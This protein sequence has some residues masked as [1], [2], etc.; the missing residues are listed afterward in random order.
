MPTAY[1]VAADPRNPMPRRTG[2]S[3][4]SVAAEGRDEPAASRS[5]WVA[6][7]AVSSAAVGGYVLVVGVALAAAGRLVAHVSVPL[8]GAGSVPLGVLGLLAMPA[9]VFLFVALYDDADLRRPTWPDGHPPLADAWLLAVVAF[10]AVTALLW[11]P[12]WPE[13]LRGVAI[14]AL[15]FVAFALAPVWLARR[16]L[17]RASWELGTMAVVVT[18]LLLVWVGVAGVVLPTTTAP[19]EVAVAAPGVVAP[20]WLA[21][22][23]PGPSVLGRRAARRLPGEVRR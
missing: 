9:A 3:D 14:G 23:S 16:C 19:V 8:P 15:W 10:A 1:D 12:A 6:R 7:A 4:E 11:T 17:A 5:E 20:Y 22:R 13:L 21:A 18:L 2:P